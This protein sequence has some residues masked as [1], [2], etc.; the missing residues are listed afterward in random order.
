MNRDLTYKRN[1]QIRYDM[2]ILP[3]LKYPV[4]IRLGTVK[5]GFC[6]LTAECESFFLP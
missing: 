5:R 2:F 4:I 1:Y 3:I 6:M